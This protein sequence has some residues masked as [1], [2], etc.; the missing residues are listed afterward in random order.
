MTTHAA[1]RRM[2]NAVALGGGEICANIIGFA[3]TAYLAVVL[4]PERFGVLAFAIAVVGYVSVFLNAGFVDVGSRNI[5]REPDRAA[6]IATSLTIVRLGVA[7]F[8]FTALVI[9]AWLLESNTE[10]ALVLILTGLMLFAAALDTSWVY[11]GLEHGIPVSLSLISRR[12]VFAVLVILLVSGPRHMLM[13]PVAQVIGELIGVLWLAHLF[14]KERTADVDLVLGWR[15]FRS[16]ASLIA[17]KLL[18]TS[19][20]SLDVILLGLIMTDRAVGLYSAPYRFCFFLMAIAAAIQVAYLP[21]IGKSVPGSERRAAARRHLEMSATLGIPFAAGGVFVAAPLIRFLFGNDYVEGTTAFQV[22]LCGV[23]VLFLFSPLHNILLAQNRLR[24][25]FWGIA[26]AAV[27]NLVLNLIWIPIYGILGAAW[28]TLIAEIVILVWAGAAVW[29][30]MGFTLLRPLMPPC[31]GSGVMIAVLFA[32][33]GEV[34][35]LYV[36]IPVGAA[37]FVATLIILRQV[38]EDAVSAFRRLVQR[39]GPA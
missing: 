17:I 28:A 22:L 21:H 32:L 31:V 18:R 36:S 6:V 26:V 34:S 10:H 23:G 24:W 20:I 19:I 14:Y 35:P 4:G 29:P 15:M 16:C 25:E 5:A 1:T 38:P 11:K 8:C 33:P 7:T 39:S 9:S 13:A 27:L 37:V 12:L 30:A 3:A 2:R